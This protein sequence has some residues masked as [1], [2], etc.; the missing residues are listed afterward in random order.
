MRKRALVTALAIAIAVTAA[1]AVVVTLAV[2]RD[3]SKNA[4]PGIR[5]LALT[6]PIRVEQGEGRT[7]WMVP[8]DSEVLV[9]DNRSPVGQGCV[10]VLRLVDEESGQRP[11]AG[12]YF[13]DPC[14]GAGWDLHGEYV[15]AADP[16]FTPAGAPA[17]LTLVG[18]LTLDPSA[19]PAGP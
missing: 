15:G 17:S 16:N 1:I 12:N 19:E 2:E 14:T 10:L 13:L 18:R 6:R 3:E 4:L 11:F 8:A 5:A 7:V 9:F